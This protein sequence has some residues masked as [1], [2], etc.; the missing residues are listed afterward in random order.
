M[1]H[2]LLTAW[3]QHFGPAIPHVIVRAPG[4]I[5]IIGEHTDYN[6][7]WVMPG[8]MSRSLY[9]LT[10]LSPD[11]THHWVAHDL[12]DH[13]RSADLP[14]D[15]TLQVWAKYITGTLQLNGYNPGPLQILMGGDLPVGAGVSSSSSLI[16]GVLFALD[17]LQGT[18]R[19][20]ETIA[21]LASRVEREII[22]LQGGIMD[23]Y[24]IMLS[25]AHFVMVLD[26]RTQ[27]YHYI[28]AELSG[29]KWLL[30]NTKVK[31]QLIDSEYNDRAEECNRAVR[32][33]QNQYPDVKSL[34][35]VDI[36]M[37]NSIHLPEVISRRARFV[38]AENDRV[39][40]MIHA[41]EAKDAVK[42][43]QLLNASH[44]GLRYEYE[45]S[46]D[47]L[48]H[49]ADFAQNYEGVFGARMMGGGFGGCVIC[50][51]SEEI[52][53]AF[54]AEASEQYHATFG[55]APEVI[56]LELSDGVSIISPADR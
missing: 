18:Q 24:A 44:R 45:V 4:R 34:R 5:N 36:E 53:D 37:I 15:S 47:E 3:H 14:D 43:G 2:Q 10:S 50:L 22:G 28:T 55:F 17:Q 25:K 1:L 35:D 51:V 26:C 7:G 32:I 54:G 31:H 33:I 27:T 16:C 9:I 13:F 29:C 20:G 8:A 30:L 11:N 52:A 38:L 41:L 12:Q 19:T 6:E 39:H 49:F 46:C 48:N 56:H 40:D 23:Q 21:L 42:A